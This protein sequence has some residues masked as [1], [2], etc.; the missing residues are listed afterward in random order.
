MDG[1]I[2]NAACRTERHF[3]HDLPVNNSAAILTLPLA[4]AGDSDYFDILSQ[5]PGMW[6]WKSREHKYICASVS[7]TQLLGFERQRDI[8][9]RHDWS[10]PCRAR[11]C[12]EA[13]HLQDHLVMQKLAP[14]RILDIAQFA[15]GEWRTQITTKSPLFD[16]KNR[17]IGVSF[18]V[19]D[20]AS[21]GT[22]ELSRALDKDYARLVPERT[23]ERMNTAAG[24]MNIHKMTSRESEVLFFLLRGHNTKMIAKVLEVSHRTIEHHI[25]SLKHKFGVANKFDLHYAAVAHGYL[26]FLPPSLLRKQLSIILGES[27]ARI[28]QNIPEKAARSA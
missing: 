18:H 23:A 27:S 8:N 7:L 12:A 2:A 3:P 20:T 9:G 1:D 14:L 4:A 28:G 21:L 25:D 22:I 24:D 26:N 13:Y 5:I 15:G 16:K 19:V 10:L 11:E 6:G 17:V